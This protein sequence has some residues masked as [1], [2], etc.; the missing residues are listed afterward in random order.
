MENG[1]FSIRNLELGLFFFLKKAATTPKIED[2]NLK[3]CTS[4]THFRHSSL[5]F[6]THFALLQ[7]RHI[8]IKQC[9]FTLF[10]LKYRLH[11]ETTGK[12][13]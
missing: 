8:Y 1:I 4:R 6:K 2:S 3:R 7:T 12:S 9:L 10:C 13:M 11:E 5:Q